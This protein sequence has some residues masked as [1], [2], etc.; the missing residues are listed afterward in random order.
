VDDGA[1][2]VATTAQANRARVAAKAFKAAKTAFK[3]FDLSKFA[4]TELP[5]NYVAPN[6]NASALQHRTIADTLKTLAN[7]GSAR[8][9]MTIALPAAAIEQ[10]LASF[11]KRKSTVELSELLRLLEGKMNGTEFYSSGHPTLKRLSV[12]S[13]VNRLIATI[14]G[15]RE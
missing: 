2:I 12:Q 8:T 13:E 6:R 5:R 15:H 14:K 1:A 3:R 10:Q 7:R 9:P 11:N 4:G